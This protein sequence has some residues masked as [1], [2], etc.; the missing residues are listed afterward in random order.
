MTRTRRELDDHAHNPLHRYYAPH[1]R[2]WTPSPWPAAI[3]SALVVAGFFWLD[4]RPGLIPAIVIGVVMGAGFGWIRWTI[5]RRRHPV[6]TVDEYITDLLR[7]R[8]R[9]SKWN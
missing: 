7:E 8:R 1:R 5:W 3:L 4:P 6:I 9:K 2:A